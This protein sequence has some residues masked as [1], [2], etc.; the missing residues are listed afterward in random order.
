MV[1][2]IL[3]LQS[4]HTCSIEGAGGAN[5][6]GDR[7]GCKKGFVEEHGCDNSAAAVN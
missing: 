1:T 6:H 2:F 7:D 4:R 3:A 5:E